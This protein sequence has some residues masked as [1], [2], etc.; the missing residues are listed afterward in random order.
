M[1]DQLL[2]IAQQFSGLPMDSLIGVPLIATTKAN[3]NMAFAQTQFLL[4]N[5]F[6]KVVTGSGDTATTNYAPIMIQMSLTNNVIT[7]GDPNTTPPTETTV[8]PFTTVF[9]LPI[10]TII[11]LNSLA[12][13]TVDVN[14]E[15]EVQS[16]SAQDS[17]SETE[18][19]GRF[20]EKVGWGPFS[21]AIHG[22]AS[23]DSKE[24]STTN[25]HYKK[26]NSAK[27][28][29]ALQ[30]GQLPLPQGVLTIID[31]FSKNILPVQLPAQPKP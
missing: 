28:S 22:S 11:P 29:I 20:E 3:A 14:F 16:I 15:V 26:H 25:S 5:C 1:D 19:E 7:P 21:V 2:L 17:S 30:A 12:V 24:S 6:N 8:T 9:N 13:E 10:L 4:D 31:A 27:Y 18:G 23:Y